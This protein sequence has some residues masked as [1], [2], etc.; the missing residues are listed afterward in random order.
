[1]DNPQL[2]TPPMSKTEMLVR[3][4]AVEVFEAI[5]NPDIT[6]QYWYT[7]GSGRLEVGKQVRWDWEMYD[8]SVDVTPRLIEPNQRIVIE[9]HGYSGPTTVEWA[10][11]PH[12]DD[13]TFV[14]ITEKGFTGDADDLVRYAVDST[15][16]F[17][18]MLAGLKALLEHGVKLNLT[19]D[20]HPR[21]VVGRGL[22]GDG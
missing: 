1:M 22:L 4:P 17:T 5:V 11:V 3:K 14:R 19:A 2:T 21:G 6:A 16:G 15:Q 7:R 20:A 13:T 12:D 8:V 9:W 10:L 18:W